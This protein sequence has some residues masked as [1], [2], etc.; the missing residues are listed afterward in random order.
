M[1]ALCDRCGRVLARAGGLV[2]D[3]RPPQWAF[4]NPLST[5]SAWRPNAIIAPVDLRPQGWASTIGVERSTFPRSGAAGRDQG[6]T[7]PPSRPADRPR[8]APN[9][10]GI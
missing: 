8:S 3:H 10:R 7:R 4:A 6:F 1:L 2:C 9:A 5:C